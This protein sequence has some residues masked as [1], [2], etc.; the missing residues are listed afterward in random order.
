MAGAAWWF[1]GDPK[2]AL[3]VL[4]IATPCPLILAVPVGL[5]MKQPDLGTAI[6][7][8][9]SGVYVLFFAGLSWRSSAM[10]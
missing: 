10:S 5:I 7:I 3:A 1:S 9:A 4:V 2:R 8:L 6:L